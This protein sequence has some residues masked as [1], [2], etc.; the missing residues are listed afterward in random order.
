MNGKRAVS[1]YH[2]YLQNFFV[3]MIVQARLVVN[4]ESIRK[5]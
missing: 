3:L 1:Q 5:H 4:Y 2:A